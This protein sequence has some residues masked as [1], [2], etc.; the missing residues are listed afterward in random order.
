MKRWIAIV[1]TFMIVTVVLIIIAMFQMDK[2]LEKSDAYQAAAGYL[3]SE[4]INRRYGS[5]QKDGLFSYSRISTEKTL[6]GTVGT[7]VF[8]YEAVDENGDRFMV[9]IRLT[10]EN[11]SW[12]VTDCDIMKIE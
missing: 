3:S 2:N 12:V 1:S 5:L 10:M 9:K 4:E 11:Q 6:N 7:A 8:Q